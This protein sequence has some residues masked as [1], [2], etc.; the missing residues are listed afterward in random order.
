MSAPVLD[1]ITFKTSR[2][3]EFC[4]EKELINQTGH[5]SDCWPLVVLKEVLDNKLDACEE[6]GVAPDI[7]ITVSDDRFAV[8]DN[9]PGIA[10]DTVADQRHLRAL[11]QDRAQRV[12]PCRVPQKGVPFNR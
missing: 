4:S 10:P 1:R 2:L 3:V 7:N 9:G 8:T 12:L 6:S 11:P 5:H